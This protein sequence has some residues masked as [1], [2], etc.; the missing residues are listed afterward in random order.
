M[1]MFAHHDD[2]VSLSDDYFDLCDDTIDD[3]L[4]GNVTC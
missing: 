3:L 4:G 2:I 1:I